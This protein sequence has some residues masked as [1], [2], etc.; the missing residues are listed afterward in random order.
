PTVHSTNNSVFLGSCQEYEIPLDCRIQHAVTCQSA[1][2]TLT[3]MSL[4]FGFCRTLLSTLWR[5]LRRTRGSPLKSGNSKEECNAKKSIRTRWFRR[6]HR[7]LREPRP[8]TV[9]Q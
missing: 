7:V 6:A 4:R 2:K 5:Q 3:R 8:C 1:E 9:Q